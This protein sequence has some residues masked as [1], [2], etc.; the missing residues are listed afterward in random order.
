MEFDRSCGLLLHISSLPGELGIGDVGPSARWFVDFLRDAGQ[1]WWQILPLGPS[2]DGNPYIA[3]STWAGAPFL[4]SLQDLADEG[5]LRHEEL[6]DVH[7]AHNHL[8]DFTRARTVHGALLRLA[9][10]RFLGRRAG[11][12]RERFDAFCQEQADWLDDWALYA[13]ARR[14]HKDAAWWTW[15]R[16]LALREP[17]AL[18]G[19]RRRLDTAIRN[20][21]YVQFR[22]REQWDRLRGR[23]R[24]AGI[25]LIGDLPIYCSRDSADVWAAQDHFQLD[26]NGHPTA[27][28]G[29]PPDYFAADGQLWGTP[30]Y[31]WPRHEEE[32]FAWWI[33]RLQAVLALV[34]V[35][36][37]DHFRAF[38]SY[39]E[40]PADASTARH[41][42]WLPGPG[43]AF[44]QAVRDALG[45]APLIAED[46]GI[47][48]RD[49]DE[50]RRRWELP[51]MKVLQF[52][53]GQGGCSPHLPVY[54]GRDSVVYSGTHDNDTSRGWFR[55]ASE[56]EKDHFRRF[57]ASDGGSA[58]YHM[59]LTAHRSVGDLAIVPVQDV[60]GLD[61]D[62]RMNIPGV[63]T[64]N[65]R[66][67]LLPGQLDPGAATMMREMALICGRL[68]GQRPAHFH[69]G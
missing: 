41:G 14:H 47:I 42:R 58:H 7:E 39:W 3:Q 19:W 69:E 49:V 63:A 27:V 53:F 29:V 65:W 52:A 44:F 46:L 50:L 59:M 15:P 62:A 36:R 12:D 31:D 26:E 61:S 32:E 45:D 30:L 34:D 4:V 64:G 28:S 35:V 8:V 20:E 55:T 67:R 11:H 33:S 23:A 5:D 10:G 66:W 40:V 68:P 1:S 16:D 21:R 60:L 18:D 56:E 22:F 37:V 13:A 43:D 25:R 2:D 48:T 57:T 38:A 6:R 17:A 9:A 54:H 24:D 51:G